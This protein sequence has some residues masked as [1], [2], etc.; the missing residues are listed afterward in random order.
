M[1]SAIFVLSLGLAVAVASGSLADHAE[2]ITSR[3]LGA[4]RAERAAAAFV[5]S[6][7]REGCDRRLV[8]A[9]RLDG[10]LLSGCIQQ[11]QIQQSQGGS[12]LRVEAR[13]PWSPRLFTG[14]T[15]SLSRV[16]VGLRGFSVSAG[17]V[18]TPCS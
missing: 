12:F 6:C 3:N 7:G 14:L 15:P 11:S 16:A 13:V 18:L 1:Q 5:S 8:N 2:L 9:T 10:T 17:A 4:D